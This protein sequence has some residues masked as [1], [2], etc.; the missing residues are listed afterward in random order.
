MSPVETAPAWSVLAAAAQRRGRSRTSAACPRP[1]SGTARRGARSSGPCEPGDARG[2]GRRARRRGWPL[3]TGLRRPN[4]SLRSCARGWLR[5]RSR[6][7]SRP[8]A[9]RRGAAR[10]RR[11]RE[12]HERPSGIEAP[13]ASPPHGAADHPLHGQGRRRQDLGRR[14]DGAP[15]RGR[16]P[17]HARPVHRPRALARRLARHAARRPSRRRSASGLWGQQVVGA[18]R[19]GAQ[20]GGGAGLARRDARRARRRS[21]Q[22]RGAHRPARASTSCS[23]C[24]RS[25]ATTRRATSTA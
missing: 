8:R 1:G 6:R 24:C 12:E 13:V 25:S 20:L 9:G 23:A 17:A 7:R 22:R 19:D 2:V 15:L 16:G 4:V 3:V 10:G 11:R 21:H 14:R 18:G 5:R